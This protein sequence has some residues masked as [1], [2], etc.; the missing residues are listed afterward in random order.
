[1]RYEEGLTEKRDRAIVKL[2]NEDGS[3][4][5]S[6]IVP[7]EK[8]PLTG[9]YKVFHCENMEV[10]TDTR[11]FEIFDRHKFKAGHCYSNI[12]VLSDDLRK[13][14]YNNVET[15]AGWLFVGSTQ[16]PVHHCWAVLDGKHVLDPAD[17]FTV[18]MAGSNIDNFRDTHTYHDGVNV[19]ADFMQAAKKELNHIVCSPVGIPSECLLYIGSKC[20]PEQARRVYRELMRKFPDHECDRTNARGMN[21]TQKIMMQKGVFEI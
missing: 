19:M 6:V 20:E 13:E 9:D 21:L 4:W 18:M 16:L 11:V 14:G 17:F 8:Y 3:F 15:Y 12:K 7:T 2:R 1:M 5:R 10:V